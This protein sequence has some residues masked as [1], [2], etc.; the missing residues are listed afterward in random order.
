[1]HHHPAGVVLFCIVMI[2][3]FAIL[4]GTLGNKKA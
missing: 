4:L 3:A 2:S 1:M